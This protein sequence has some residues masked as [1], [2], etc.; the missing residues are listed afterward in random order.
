M[1]LLELDSYTFTHEQFEVGLESVQEATE[2][3][4][5]QYI[6]L[7]LTDE[8]LQN[9]KDAT[10]QELIQV[11]Q[12]NLSN[13]GVITRLERKSKVARYLQKK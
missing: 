4:R 8:D 1:H 9:F 3:D 12:W 5:R 2:E 7:Y 13:L 10:L 6:S 11:A